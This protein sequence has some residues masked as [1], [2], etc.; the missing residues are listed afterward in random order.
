MKI[1]VLLMVAVMTFAVFASCSSAPATK[2][3]ISFFDDIKGEFVVET[4]EVEL[5][6]ANPTV[7]DAVIAVKDMFATLDD[8]ANIEFTDDGK[9]VMNVDACKENLDGDPLEFW[10]FL[11]NDKEPAGDASD[12]AVKDGDVI[13]YNFVSQAKNENN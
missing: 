7:M 4:V 9:S 6:K 11:V 3:K 1:A 13:V 5:T 2:V 8:Y 12:V 10:S